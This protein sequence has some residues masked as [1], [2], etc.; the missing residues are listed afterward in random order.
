[1]NR[2]LVPFT[3][4]QAVD[5]SP[6][7][8]NLAALTRDTNARLKAVE[9]LIPIDLR[10]AIQ[11]GPV[12]EQDWCLLVRGNAAAAKLRQLLPLLQARLQAKGWQV[13]TI[14]I[15]VQSARGAPRALI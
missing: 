4:Q 14:R 11:A 7:L 3:L 8:A 2:R 13:S 5:L 6:T 12:N 15:K 1:M 9:G 10:G